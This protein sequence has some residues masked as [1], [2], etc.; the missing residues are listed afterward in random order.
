MTGNDSPIIRVTAE[1]LAEVENA[2]V[3]TPPVAQVDA[4]SGVRSYGNINSSFAETAPARSEERPSLLL[5]GWFYLGAAGLVGA[6]SGW[7]IC[8]RGFIDSEKSH[9]WGNVWLLPMVTMMM[10][11]AF[12]LAESLVERSLKKAVKRLLVVIPLGIVCGFVFDGAANIIY[13][14]GLSVI[15]AA[16]VRTTRNPAWW[17]TRAFAWAVFGVAAGL[18][19]GFVGK[20][21]KKAKYGV[22][23]GA[24]GA[25]LGGLAFDPI[26]LLV[27]QG[28]Q[29]RAFGLGLLGVAAGAA[30]GFV[31]SAL[32]DR[33]IY[34]SGGPLAGKQFILYKASTT[35]GSDQG[36]DIYLFKDPNIAP[37]HATIEL[38]GTQATLHAQAPIFISGV[39]TQNRVLLSGDIIQI[40][41]YVF[42]YNERHR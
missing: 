20:S 10:L 40:G 24:V 17:I 7:G 35:I 37:L 13:E 2:A 36:S 8:E 18:I 30:M 3:S 5:Q 38:R 25:F 9:S 39:P 21:S 15:V 4:K 26:A 28:A 14:V 23:G 22:I 31:E 33:W 12:A 19:Y 32:K 6:I 11:I 16:G 41:R 27:D 42:K 1:D 34:V 29:S